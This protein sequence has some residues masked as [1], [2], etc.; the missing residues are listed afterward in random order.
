MTRTAHKFSIGRTGDGKW[1]AVSSQS[2]H[3]CFAGDTAVAVEEQASRALELF[4][5]TSGRLRSAKTKSLTTFSK[6]K[7]VHKDFAEA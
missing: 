2:P 4:F 5:G 3:F 1:L 6:D 7:T